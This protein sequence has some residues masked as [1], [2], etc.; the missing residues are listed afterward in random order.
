VGAYER[1]IVYRGVGFLSGQFPLRDG[2]LV[3][4]G[5]VGAELSL[6][7]GRQAAE[8]AALNVIAQIKAVLGGDL[9]HLET[10]LRVDGHVASAPDFVGQPTV[11][12]GASEA[13]RRLLGER[14]RHTRTAFAAPRLPLDAP[15]ELAV[16][17]GVAAAFDQNG[18]R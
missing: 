5:R 1:G 17:F 6:E 9:A 18:R 12:D 16:T 7:E 8:I 15:I 14:G 10:L 4:S 13:F 11:L 2:K 3:L